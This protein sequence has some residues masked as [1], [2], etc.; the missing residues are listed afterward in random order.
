MNASIS[1]I[2]PFRNAGATLDEA[3]SGLLAGGDEGVE[4]LAIDDGSTDSGPERVRTWSEHD[5]RVRFVHNDGRGL[6]A[7]LRTG[8]QLAR[9]GLVARMD[10][11]DVAHPTR[12]RRQREHLLAHPELS[13]LGTQVR[14]FTV[15]D[16]SAP[17]EGLVRYVAWQNALVTAEQ[18]RLARFIESPLCHP[19]VMMRRDALE[20]V[21]GYREFDGPE[22][23][24]LFL[25][26]I[27]HGHRL[28]KLPEV[29]LDWRHRPGRATFDDARYS[30]DRFR[31]TKAPYLARELARGAAE[32]VVIWGAGPTGRRLARALALH[33]IRPSLFI[34]I[35]PAKIGRTAQGA[36]IVGPDAL[37]AGRDMVVAAVGARGA[38]ALIA[39]DLTTRSFQE[40]KNAW[41]AS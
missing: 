40:G 16:A 34:D 2:V 14:A 20:A 19:S 8:L 4:V 17:G 37:V 30:L 24:E 33:D 36:P 15:D 32:N 31:A 23:Y 9:G 25:R 39:K 10:A 28:E 18:H 38:R 29:L 26:M 13:V 1:V 5:P 27:E 7:A 22:D 6:V 11:D 21:G 3:L 41:F 12:L 35:D